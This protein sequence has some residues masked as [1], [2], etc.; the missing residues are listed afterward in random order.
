MWI[1]RSREESRWEVAIINGKLLNK[2][3]WEIIKLKTN[4][5]RVPTG[6]W[7]HLREDMWWSRTRCTPEDV[8]QKGSTW[9]NIILS[10]RLSSGVFMFYLASCWNWMHYKLWQSVTLILEE[11]CLSVCLS[12]RRSL[13]FQFVV[14]CD[15][16]EISRLYPSRAKHI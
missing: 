2:N 15:I 3:K 12:S 6:I 14:E 11:K 16:L 5:C 9:K 1:C 7:K 4:K 8:F 13:Q 10:K